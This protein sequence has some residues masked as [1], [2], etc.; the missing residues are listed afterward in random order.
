MIIIDQDVRLANAISV[1]YKA[2]DNRNHIAE[3]SMYDL[4][5]VQIRQ[6]RRCASDLLCVRESALSPDKDILRTMRSR[7]RSAL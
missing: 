7:S 1:M 6:A 3:I 4:D 5:G 2:I